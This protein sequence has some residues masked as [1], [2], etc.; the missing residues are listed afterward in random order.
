MI[1][2]KLYENFLSALK[3]HDS[4]IDTQY[5]Y[6]STSFNR[7]IKSNI[8]LSSQDR[9]IMYLAGIKDVCDFLENDVDKV[10]AISC[11]ASQKVLVNK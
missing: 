10:E 3:T 1:Y 11:D 4:N 8:D 7:K 2:K 6:L 9:I 5:E